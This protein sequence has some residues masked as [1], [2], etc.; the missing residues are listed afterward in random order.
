MKFAFL[1]MGILIV[2]QT[3]PLFIMVKHKLS[4]FLI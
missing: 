3:E 2:Q 1:I 4:M